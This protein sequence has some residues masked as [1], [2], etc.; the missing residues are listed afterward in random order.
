MKDLLIQ[1]EAMHFKLKSIDWKD[2]TAIKSKTIHLNSSSKQLQ[3][4]ILK[5]NSHEHLTKEQKLYVIECLRRPGMCIS[6]VAKMLM[7]RYSTVYSIKKEFDWDFN[8][9]VSPFGNVQQRKRISKASIKAIDEYLSNQ[10]ES[11]TVNDINKAVKA[12]TSEDIKNYIVRKYIKET[13]G[14]SYRRWTSKPCS[15]D[16]PKLSI[17][18][19]LFSYRIGNQLS[20]SALM[21]SLDETTFNHKVANNKSWIRNGYS[22][23]LFNCRFVGSWSLIMAITNEGSYFGLLTN[24]RVNS[25]FY[26]QFFENLEW[27]IE[28]KR[29]SSSQKVVILKD[30][31]Q[32]HR[33]KKVLSFIETSSCTYVYIPMYT[34]EF[35]PVEKIFAILKIRCKSL[36]LRGSINWGKSE[37]YEIVSHEMAAIDSSQIVAIW[38]NFVHIISSNLK[39]L[40]CVV[41]K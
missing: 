9:D 11:F 21:I 32:V 23:E 31:W 3:D 8:H 7:M 27:W 19:S 35:S 12:R 39:V 4:S 34:P 36:R 2:D 33:A 40:L 5:R 29:S 14:M 24:G 37:G 20:E 16:V 30:N 22:A 26:L 15:V 17:L 25:W 13:L 28:S 1:R 41:E 10:R 6:K 18:R 38:R